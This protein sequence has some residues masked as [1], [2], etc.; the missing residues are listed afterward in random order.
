[1]KV[2]FWA[3]NE[4]EGGGASRNICL[5]RQSK[6]LYVMIRLIISLTG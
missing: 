5:R 3:R 6:R 2:Y 1:M 4:G